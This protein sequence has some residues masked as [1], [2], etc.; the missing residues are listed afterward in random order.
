[1]RMGEGPLFGNDFRTSNARSWPI[2]DV[3]NYIG[4]STWSLQIFLR[5][6]TEFLPSTILTTPRDCF[7][8]PFRL[9]LRLSSIVISEAF[10]HF[11]FSAKGSSLNFSLL[12]NY[13]GRTPTLSVRSLTAADISA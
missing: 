4:S 12:G 8:E 7:Y 11:R 6:S 13:V 3:P 5:T 2:S 1:M 9:T 10:R